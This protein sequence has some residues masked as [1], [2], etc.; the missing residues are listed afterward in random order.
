MAIVN[1]QDGE[2]TDGGTV[3]CA[4]LTPVPPER[5]RRIFLIMYGTTTANQFVNIKV[6]IENPRYETDPS[7]NDSQQA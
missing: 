6:Y 3:N 7:Y 1:L 5:M 4:R 2:M